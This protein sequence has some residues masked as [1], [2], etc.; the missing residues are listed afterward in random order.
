MI[1]YISVP[2]STTLK[3]FSNIGLTSQGEIYC[4]SHANIGFQVY[5]K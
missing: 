4:M 3:K 5:T 1:D 2:V